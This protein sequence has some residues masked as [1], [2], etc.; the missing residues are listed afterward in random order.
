MSDLGFFGPKA[1]ENYHLHNLFSKELG[2]G[3]LY[4]VGCYPIHF[5]QMI[6]KETG[7]KLQSI[8]STIIYEPK[9][10]VDETAVAILRYSKE[11]N[12]NVSHAI[13]TCHGSIVGKSH[14]LGMISGT[15]GYIQVPVFYK[16][17]RFTLVENSPK[18]DGWYNEK[19]TEFQFDCPSNGLQ[20]EIL[21]FC[22][23]LKNGKLESDIVSLQDSLQVVEIKQNI[24]SP[25]S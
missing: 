4:A 14:L 22:D 6:F 20:Y 19:V 24:L 13:S 2:G 8:Q 18:E 15:K 12:Q 10:G 16:P 11:V 9:T 3:S 23:L 7:F 25:K 5:A 1:S 21:H 17:T